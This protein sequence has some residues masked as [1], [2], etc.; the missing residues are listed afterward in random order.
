MISCNI[1]PLELELVIFFHGFSMLNLTS[2]GLI[3]LSECFCVGML[4][5]YQFSNFN[6][7]I[8]CLAARLTLMWSSWQQLE[9]VSTIWWHYN[10]QLEA[11]LTL[12]LVYPFTS[13]RNNQS[14]M[15]SIQ[16][17]PSHLFCDNHKLDF[18]EMMVCSLHQWLGICQINS[19]MSPS[20]LALLYWEKASKKQ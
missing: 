5:T 16:P 12:G 9:A 13:S 1:P 17:K 14:I 15:F 8:T 7:R 2:A 11:N 10:M 6:L 18:Y 20:W 19:W 4:S 3:S